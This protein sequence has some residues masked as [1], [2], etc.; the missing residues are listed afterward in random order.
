MGSSSKTGFLGPGAFRFFLALVVVVHH[1]F[2]FRAGTWAVYV[3]FILS[4]YWITK[5]W[6]SRYRQT[7]NSYLTFLVSR[8]WRL[9]PVF[10]IC[11]LL[12]FWSAALLHDRIGLALLGNPVWWLCQIPI[13]GS[14]DGGRIL[15]PSWSLDVEMQFYLVAPLAIYLVSKAPSKTR[16]PI[17]AVL[18]ILLGFLVGLGF[19]K[20]APYFFI[21]AGFFFAGIVLALGDWVAGR[22]TIFWGIAALFIGIAVLVAFPETR[23]GIWVE[24]NA[25]FSPDNWG[26]VWWVIAATLMVPFVSRNVRVR[27]GRWDRFLGNLAYPLYLFHWIPREW[28]Y[29]L[30]ETNDLGLIRIVL[31]FGNVVVAISGAI[32]ILVFVDQPF[33]RLRTKWVASRALS[34]EPRPA[35]ESVVSIPVS[36]K[37]DG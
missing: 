31:L 19:P 21:F 35:T 7:R 9:A 3:F 5:M 11:I 36:G 26:S 30:C 23:G 20:E 1:S 2:P 8:W 14:S 13:A 17:V 34:A 27:S 18:L 33:E 29:H 25:N 22:S 16:W 4:G 28:Y 32:A 10:F 15:A 12:G 37:P 6:H 24:G